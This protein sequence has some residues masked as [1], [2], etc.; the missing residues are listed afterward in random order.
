MPNCLADDKPAVVQ[1]QRKNTD[2]PAHTDAVYSCAEHAVSLDLAA[3][4]H[5]STCTAPGT[6]CNCT[7]TPL[8]TSPADEPP[9][10]A[11]LPPGW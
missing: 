3:L 1:W 11:Q 2:D 5:E 10:P 6:A 9:E 8:A 4:L 7:P